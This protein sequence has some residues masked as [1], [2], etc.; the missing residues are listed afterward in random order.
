MVEKYKILH[1]NFFDLET[2]NEIEFLVSRV[3]GK[4]KRKYKRKKAFPEKRKRKRKR[5]TSFLSQLCV[6]KCKSIIKISMSSHN[7]DF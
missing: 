3:F 2:K 4:R 1:P 6:D 5:K 7:Y